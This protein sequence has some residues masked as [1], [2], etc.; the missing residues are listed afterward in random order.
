MRCSVHLE[1]P[2]PVGRVKFHQGAGDRDP[3]IQDGA[4]DR[5][6]RGEGLG[7]ETHCGRLVCQVA[8]DQR[9][10]DPKRREFI[11]RRGEAGRVE[12]AERER[13]ARARQISGDVSPDP[14]CRSGDEK[15][16]TREVDLHRR[17]APAGLRL[18][19]CVAA[20]LGHLADAFGGLLGH[21]A[22]PSPSRGTVGASIDMLS[23]RTH[24]AASSSM[25]CGGGPTAELPAA[26]ARPGT[27]KRRRYRR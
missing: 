23:C 25:S 20:G 26:G 7:D 8:G 3:R 27:A 2:P 11:A 10:P 18:A 24:G 6:V 15:G 4:V 16:S 9:W 19:R 14:G 13:G 12:V 22:G 1:A 5:A 17:G 21:L